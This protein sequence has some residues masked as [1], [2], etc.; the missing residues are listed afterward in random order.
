MRTI[1]ML[2][3]L[4]LLGLLTAGFADAQPKQEKKMDDL[5]S[6]SRTFVKQ[7][8]QEDYAAATH[9]FDATM[10]KVMPQEKLRAAW[11]AILA[12]AGALKQQ[13]GT[14]TTKAQG[15]DIVIVT[16]EFVLAKIDIKLVFDSQKRIAGLFFSPTDTSSE[17]K[18]A[19]YAR[20]GTFE[21]KEVAVGS[22][23][24]VLKGS[25]TLPLGS[26]PFPALV[27][28][29]GSGPHDRDET[30]GPNKPFRDL[31]EGLASQGIAVLRYEK[32]THAYGNKLETIK[33]FTVNQETVDDAA[34]AAKLLLKTPGI[35][36]KRVFVL[37]HSLGGMILHRVVKAVP[38]VH[39]LI[40]MAGATRP[41]DEVIVEQTAYI[42][43]LQ[44]KLTDDDKAKIEALKQDLARLK[45]PEI[46]RTPE[47]MIMGAPVSYWLDLRNIDPPKEAK[48][49]TQ[50]MLIL[51]GGKDYQVTEKDFANWKQA[52]SSHKNAVFKFYPD[53]YHLFMPGKKTPADYE[54]AGHVEKV[55]VDD[56]AQ[57]IH[58]QR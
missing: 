28:V 35:D 20:P 48:A 27:L 16:C 31:A 12:Q 25:L 23:E 40:M 10:Q 8:A 32:R 7:L 9:S 24:W 46:A 51:Q 37:G 57:W 1:R 49:L 15:Y 45:D 54:Q 2:I 18:S 55:V 19:P 34:A 4:I 47:K 14:R 17:Y 52:L 38:Q 11:H 58:G 53:L 42:A 21:E 26:G 50:S 39:G 33:N 41:L 3:G 43:G 5:L 29:H 44:A 6:L 30:I 56:I 36:R 13:L 22:G